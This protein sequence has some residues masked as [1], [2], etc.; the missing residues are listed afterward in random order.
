MQDDDVEEIP[1]DDIIV[2]AVP[3]PEIK[4]RVNTFFNNEEEDS[5][6]SANPDGAS[7]SAM[8]KAQKLPSAPSD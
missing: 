8:M 2:A 7:K 4:P 1:V 3:D 5:S 6:R